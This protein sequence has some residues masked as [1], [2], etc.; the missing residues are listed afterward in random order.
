MICHTWLLRAIPDLSI[1]AIIYH[2]IT[3]DII[4]VHCHS[5]VQFLHSFNVDCMLH[6]GVVKQNFKSTFL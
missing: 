2:N 4:D 1:L 3:R 6:M 5:L